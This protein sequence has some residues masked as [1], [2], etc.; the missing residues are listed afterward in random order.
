MAQIVV[1]GVSGLAMTLSN[2]FSAIFLNN[3]LVIHGGDMAVS[4]FGLINR[5]VV[6]VFMPCMVIGQ[7]MQPIMGFN[8][9]AHRYD[10][11]FKA[12]KISLSWATGIAVAGFL[13]FYFFPAQ[14]MGIFTTEKELIAQ[15]VHASKRMFLG[16]YLIGFILVASIMFQALGKAVQSFIASVARPALILIPMLYFMAGYWHLEGIWYTF[17]ITDGL[18]ALVILLLLMPQIRDLRRKRDSER[19]RREAGGEP[20]LDSAPASVQ[21]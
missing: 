1:V 12:L 17:P 11:V 14:I 7:G 20:V 13:V 16:I 19:Q 3:L 15:T 6:F 21:S 10:R 5:A 9:G 2:S 8:Y 4:T 18:T